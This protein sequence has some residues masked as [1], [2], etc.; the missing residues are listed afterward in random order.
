MPGWNCSRN[1]SR[2]IVAATLLAFPIGRALQAIAQQHIETSSFNQAPGRPPEDPQQVQKGKDLYDNQCA[3]CHSGDLRG[4]ENAGPNLLRSQDALTDKQGDNL[5]P[6]IQGTKKGMTGHQ[7]APDPNDANAIAAYVR[8]VIAKVGSQGRPPGDSTRSPNILV[9][10]A[11]QG[12]QYFAAKCAGCHSVDADLKGFGSKLSSPKTLQAA[13]LRGD[14]PW[15]TRPAGHGRRD[16]TGQASPGRNADPYR[17]LFRH[18]QEPGR[19]HGNG[20]TT[21]CLAEGSGS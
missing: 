13:W 6:I 14:P 8:S 11:A 18:P 4:K 21:R 12:K 1:I 20:A 5:L 17:R 19:R 9:G 7:F 2:G 3:S 10:D 16:R 15:G